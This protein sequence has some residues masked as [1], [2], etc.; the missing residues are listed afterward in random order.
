MDWGT[1]GSIR[2]QASGRHCCAS[3]STWLAPSTRAG[4]LGTTAPAIQTL[5]H[6]FL[7]TATT[8]ASAAAWLP[9]ATWPRFLL[10]PCL[11]PLVA[12]EPP[13]Y[14]QPVP[15]PHRMVASGWEQSHDCAL[16]AQQRKE[17]VPPKAP[18]VEQ[19]ASPSCSPYLA[20]PGLDRAL[21]LQRALRVLE[22]LEVVPSPDQPQE[23]RRS[24]RVPDRDDVGCG[25]AHPVHALLAT[26]YI[27]KLGSH[28][29]ARGLWPVVGPSWFD[30]PRFR[31]RPRSRDAGS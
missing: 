15:Q 26:V 16:R 23:P 7:S 29:R 28:T 11:L 25:S 30:G 22:S 1:G 27:N 2:V 9:P 5:P 13:V 3:C 20:H 4:G 17:W 12:P 6:P 10:I 24:G 31:A 18:W 14:C 8:P 21:A 19:M